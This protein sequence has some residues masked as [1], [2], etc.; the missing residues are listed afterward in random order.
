[1]YHVT[2]GTFQAHHCKI[3]SKWAIKKKAKSLMLNFRHAYIIALLMCLPNP[4]F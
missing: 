1:M 4:A 2:V 3:K